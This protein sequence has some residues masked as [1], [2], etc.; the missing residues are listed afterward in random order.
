MT[1]TIV[2]LGVL[3]TL[4][5]VYIVALSS[6]SGEAGSA[7]GDGRRSWQVLIARI[8]RVAHRARGHGKG[9][10]RHC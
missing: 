2:A 8:R 6:R 1:N 3:V 5:W 9:P 10:R 7:L 4:F